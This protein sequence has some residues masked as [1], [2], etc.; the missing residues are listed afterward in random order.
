M[1]ERLGHAGARASAHR[2]SRD[3]SDDLL[4][5]GAIL[6]SCVVIGG[7]AGWL[8]LPPLLSEL[9]STHL[10]IE[11]DDLNDFRRV[12]AFAGAMGSL[13]FDALAVLVVVGLVI[14]ARRRTGQAQPAVSRSLVLPSRD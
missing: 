5:I 3:V 10:G 7:L 2:T 11:S 1:L 4:L 9:F 12:G 6:I 14:T 13:L 8:L